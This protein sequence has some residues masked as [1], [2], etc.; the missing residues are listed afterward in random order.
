MEKVENVKKANEVKVEFKNKY[1]MV[2]EEINKLPRKSIVLT[3]NKKYNSFIIS[4]PLAPYLSVSQRISNANYFIALTDNGIA[5]STEKVSL[6][7]PY[8]L[9]KGKRKDN[10]EYW[11][12]IDLFISMNCRLSFFL[13]DRDLFA[14]N[15][16]K[17][18]L[19]FVEVTF[20]EKEFG[21]VD[22]EI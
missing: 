19:D 22:V 21:V 1:E 14:L 17:I 20:N 3:K 7:V 9:I 8:R 12:G 6:N 2:R 13:N 10:G 18:V 16:A 15:N 11:Y 5:Q 4:F